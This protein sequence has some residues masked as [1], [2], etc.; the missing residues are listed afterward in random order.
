MRIMAY[1]EFKRNESKAELSDSIHKSKWNG[2]YQYPLY[3]FKLLLFDRAGLY[4]TS[5]VRVLITMLISFALFSI[6]YLLLIAFTSAD[7]ISTVDD[8]LGIGARAFYHSAITF[9]TIGY[10]DH[11]PYRIHSLGVISGRI[12]WTFP[13]VLLHGGFC[14]KGASLIYSS[15]SFS[16]SGLLSGFVGVTCSCFHSSIFAACPERRISGTAQSFVDSGSCINRRS[17]QSILERVGQ[18]RC[19]I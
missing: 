14:E 9:L 3:W 1:V 15:G 7:I 4:A 16:R 2:L 18:S 19:F 13:D 12:F 17:Q 6:V 8:Q 11:Y 5:P 10:G